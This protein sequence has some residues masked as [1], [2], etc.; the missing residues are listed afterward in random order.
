MRAAEVVLRCRLLE[1]VSLAGARGWLTPGEAALWRE[2]P[3]ITILAS[4]LRLLVATAAL[5]AG[6]AA[7]S[8]PRGPP[9]GVATT[10]NPP[11]GAAL[12]NPP[13]GP[14]AGA[15][16]PQ[17]QR[18]ETNPAID[19]AVDALFGLLYAFDDTG[20]RDSS[21][22]LRVLW[23]RAAL[24]G[25]GVVDDS[26]AYD[27]LPSASRWLVAPGNAKRLPEKLVE[28]LEWIGSR[29]T[30]LD[31]AVDAFLAEHDDPQIVVVGAGYDTRAARYA[32]RAAFF[33]VDLPAAVDAKKRVLDAYR[34]RTGA[35]VEVAHVPLDLETLKAE[36]PG[37][38]VATLRAAGLDDRPTL[39]L[40]EAVLFY[41]SPPS[42][43][44]A[45]DAALD[46]GARVA[47]TD[48]LAKLGLTPRGPAPP[49]NRAACEAFFADRGAFALATH[50]VRW[51]GALHYADVVAAE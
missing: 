28:K 38:L 32:G 9:P 6:A 23:T 24:A 47:L 43:A 31:A 12:G 29:T 36:A 8:A 11:P 40:F 5:L 49:P 30:F 3:V 46:A 7:L 2:C 15:G 51:G 35:D 25:R 19:A 21:K 39:F 20:A 1:S 41:L 48:S 34:S 16:P 18:D 50:D 22:N 42:A 13:G 14:P 10:G 17:K 33:E 37:H 45:L 26:V 27:C 4:M 44:A